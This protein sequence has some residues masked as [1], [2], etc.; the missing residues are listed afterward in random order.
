MCLENNK[1]EV[2]FRITIDN[3]LTF[4]N[5]IKSICQKACQKLN[6]LSRISPYLEINKKKLLLKIQ[7]KSQFSY[8]PLVYIFCSQNRKNLISKIEERFLRLIT[9]DETSTFEHLPQTNNEITTHQR[10]LQMFME[11]VFKLINGF[12][13]QSWRISFYFKKTTIIFGTFK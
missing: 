4:D 9:N 7:V 12:A 6:V 10:N 2:I 3:R 1:E 13:H 8:C 5:H 11:E